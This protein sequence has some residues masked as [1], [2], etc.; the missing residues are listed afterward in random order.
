[1]SLMERK[2]TH[3]NQIKIAVTDMQSLSYEKNW[4]KILEIRRNNQ[5]LEKVVFS[6]GRRILRNSFVSPFFVQFAKKCEEC[7]VLG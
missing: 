5:C 3:L 7:F 6:K 2:I 1:M 4:D